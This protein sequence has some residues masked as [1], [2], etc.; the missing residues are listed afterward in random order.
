MS[1]H[2]GILGGQNTIVNE[3]GIE[4]ELSYEGIKTR[5][6]RQSKRNRKLAASGEA[7][8]KHNKQSLKSPVQ[9]NASDAKQTAKKVSQNSA[10]I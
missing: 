3:E 7:S 4:E 2:R 10:Q 6:T 8:A 5:N 9:A 1:G